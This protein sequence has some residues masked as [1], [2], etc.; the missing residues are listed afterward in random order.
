MA[1]PV[2]RC[3][4]L[5]AL[6][7][8]GKTWTKIT[9]TIV[10]KDTTV[11]VFIRD[12]F[13]DSKTRQFQPIDCT[14]TGGDIFGKPEDIKAGKGLD[15]R[16][17]AIDPL[18]N[19]ILQN[20]HIKNYAHAPGEAEERKERTLLHVTCGK[21][22]LTKEQLFKMP[23][24]FKCYYGAVKTLGVKDDVVVVDLRARLTKA[25]TA[26]PRPFVFKIKEW[27][28]FAFAFIAMLFVLWLQSAG[29]FTGEF[30][31]YIAAMLLFLFVFVL[32]APC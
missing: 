2:R 23:P 22:G 1:A 3:V 28:I 30:S 5:G 21:D 17:V 10:G 7:G 15:V 26:T 8:D 11:G 13:S 25:P 32:T 27:K 19:F 12:L 29:T 18:R 14:F 6:L 16:L 4:Y 9:L 24:T 20:F 31:N